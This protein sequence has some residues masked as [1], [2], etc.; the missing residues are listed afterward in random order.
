WDHNV[1]YSLYYS[2]DNGSSWILLQANQSTTIYEWDTNTIADGSEFLVKVVVVCSEGLISSDYSDN[3]FSIE[4]QKHILSIPN[5][6]YPNGGEVVSGGI[7]IQWMKASD[8]WGHSVTYNLYY[9]SNSG[10]NWILVESNLTLNNYNW[11]ITHLDEGSNYLIKVV[12][13]CAEGLTVVDISNEAFTISTVPHNL[14]N[15]IITYPNGG[16]ILN[17][18]IQIQWNSVEDSL[19][20][21]ITYSVYFSFDNGITWFELVSNLTSNFFTWN[22]SSI[23]DG[24]NYIIRVKANCEADLYS[25]DR[26]DGVFTIQNIIPATTTIPPTTTTIT[27]TTSYI[28]ITSETTT[29]TTISED[30][31]FPNIIFVILFATSVIIIHRKSRKK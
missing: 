14:T 23:A 24:S 22:T 30:G 1:S 26:S 3:V 12:A 28:P 19:N 29:S 8:T 6:I 27:T 20:H 4:N 10:S 18:T 2:N 21:F 11:N 13:V 31:S 16:E 9:S 25:E 15:P 5:I 17:G 7:L